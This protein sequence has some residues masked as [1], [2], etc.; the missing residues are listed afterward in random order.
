MQALP[1]VFQGP[2]FNCERANEHKKGCIFVVV[3]VVVF[4]F[5][6]EGSDHT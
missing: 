3:V 5:R 2:V 6:E 4:F 1:Q